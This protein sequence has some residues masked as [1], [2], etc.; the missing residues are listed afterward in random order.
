MFAIR[1]A[2]FRLPCKIKGEV[3]GKMNKKTV[4]DVDV[5]GKKV[6]VRDVYKRQD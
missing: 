5:K 6:L 2:V 1:Q 3:V 4:A